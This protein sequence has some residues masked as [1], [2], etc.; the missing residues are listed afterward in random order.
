MSGEALGDLRRFRADTDDHDAPGA[1]EL[2]RS[3]SKL[4]AFFARQPQR[5]GDHRHDDPMRAAIVEP[6]D[7]ASERVVVNRLVGMVGRLEHRQHAA[8]FAFGGSHAA[9]L[10]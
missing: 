6:G 7:F 4:F 10:A 1:T 5:L 3:L 8:Q 2:A 9:I